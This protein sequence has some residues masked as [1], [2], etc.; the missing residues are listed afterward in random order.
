MSR[1]GEFHVHVANIPPRVAKEA[2]RALFEQRGG[3]IDT[4]QVKPNGTALILYRTPADA[5]VVLE[6]QRPFVLDGVELR[7]ARFK[8]RERRERASAPERRWEDKPAGGVWYPGQGKRPPDPP[9]PSE[10]PRQQMTGETEAESAAKRPKVLPV[11]NVPSKYKATPQ[12]RRELNRE[13]AERVAQQED[14]KRRLEHEKQV[15]QHQQQ[16]MQQQMQQQ[17]Q[18]QM[19]QQQMYVRM[20]PQQWQAQPHWVVAQPQQ[21]Q[22]QQQQLYQQPYMPQQLYSPHMA[23]AAVAPPAPAQQPPPPPPPAPASLP[24]Y[25]QDEIWVAPSRKAPPSSSSSSSQ[26]HSRHRP[27][28][29]PPPPPPPP[30]P[31]VAAPIPMAMHGYGPGQMSVL[32]PVTMPLVGAGLQFMAPPVAAAPAVSVVPEAP[33]PPPVAPKAPDAPK[34]SSAAGK[35]QDAGIAE[36]IEEEELDEGVWFGEGH[37]AAPA[38]PRAASNAAAAG[39]AGGAAAAADESN[40]NND[41]EWVAQWDSAWEWEDEATDSKREGAP[42]RQE[43][44]G[45]GTW[46]NNDGFVALEAGKVE[47]KFEPPPLPPRATPI[48]PE[49]VVAPPPVVAV[50]ASPPLSV[51]AS[52]SPERPVSVAPTVW[53]S[54]NGFVQASPSQQSSPNRPSPKRAAAAAAAKSTFRPEWDHRNAVYV[55][56]QTEYGLVELFDAFP[57]SEKAQK[58]PWLELFRRALPP[59]DPTAGISRQGLTA[60][61]SRRPE[62]TSRTDWQRELDAFLK[63]GRKRD[64]L[65]FLDRKYFLAPP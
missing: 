14:E 34:A 7:V 17:Q 11:N 48:K 64:K 50:P 60:F 23:V 37:L 31:V 55:V 28:A 54:P 5:K 45:D 38:A 59:M 20:V 62:V 15:Q 13:L 33:P 46:T 35:L 10:P 25:N 58:F 6:D 27:P 41:S 43:E 9:R 21:Q 49:P 2:V 39:A 65:L 56:V 26:Q 51:A 1:A 16:Q 18:Q 32:V 24:Q 52:A 3:V 53:R 61:M 57:K 42:R 29:P 8:S 22:Q 40:N 12:Q 36:M 63:E 19:Q 47:K 4:L 44:E 30:P